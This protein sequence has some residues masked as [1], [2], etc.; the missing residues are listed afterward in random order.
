[1]PLPDE[2][3]NAQGWLQADPVHGMP[4]S[5]GRLAVGREQ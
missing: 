2:P 4:P 5:G 1:M 3:F